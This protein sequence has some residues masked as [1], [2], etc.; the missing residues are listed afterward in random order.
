M[1]A[2][3]IV[4]QLKFTMKVRVKMLGLR[5]KLVPSARAYKLRMLSAKE[6]GACTVKA[7]ILIFTRGGSSLNAFGRRAK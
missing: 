5:S 1:N 4:Y 6:I 3:S 2:H 7:T